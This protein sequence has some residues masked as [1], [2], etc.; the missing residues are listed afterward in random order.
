MHLDIVSQSGDLVH[1][2]FFYLTAVGVGVEVV[3]LGK[4]VLVV[5]LGLHPLLEAFDGVA[6]DDKEA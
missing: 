4:A 1:V 3:E 6:E 5:D 2:L